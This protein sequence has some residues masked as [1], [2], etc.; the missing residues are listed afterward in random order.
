MFAVHIRV[1]T[2]FIFPSKIETTKNHTAV[3]PQLQPGILTPFNAHIK[4]KMCT[5]F[6]AKHR[7]K[8]T[9]MPTIWP[10]I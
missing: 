1:L 10:G 3:V 4:V 2:S 9:V 6:P 5:I 8:H 7:M